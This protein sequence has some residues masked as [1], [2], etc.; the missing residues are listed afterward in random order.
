M[1]AVPQPVL[2]SDE[3]QQALADGVGVVALESTLIAHG[4]PRGQ[5]LS[6]ARELEAIVRK[7]GAVPATIAVVDGQPRIGL[8]P[9]ALERIATDDEVAKLSIRDLG[10]ASALGRTGATTV[11]STA[12]LAALAGISVFATGGL[13]GVHREA[14]DSWD[15]SA[16]LSAL[17]GTP[18]A[19]VCAGVKSV[20]DVAATL[21]RLESL[22]VPVLGF[23]TD[24]FPGFYLHSSREPLD[25]RV[26]TAEDVVAVMDRM[27]GLGL[28][29][30][31]VV[32]ANP[33]PK[34]EQL[35]PT[36]HD[37]V[38]HSG[39]ALLQSRRIR[40]KQV[41]PFLLD[42]FHTATGGESLRVNIRVVERNA[43]LA[44]DIAVARAT[45]R[46]A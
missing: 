2:V 19:V 22:G 10:V 38:L 21:E 32:V 8:D 4:L 15:E 36:M 7:A 12:H 40:G 39:L 16:D 9:A 17:A 27:A 45:S 33:I 29:D 30:R 18:M 5:N 25:W 14:R 28:D 6:V 3:V 20:L 43:A 44:A 11:A 41:T 23:G 26:D 34:D 31:A 13:G 37:R 42:H 46:P 24:A 35:D 1:T